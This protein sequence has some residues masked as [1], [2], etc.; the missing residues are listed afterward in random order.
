M[1]VT[2][3]RPGGALDAWDVL[4]GETRWVD[5]SDQEVGGD[6]V[7]YA[8]SFRRVH[9]RTATGQVLIWKPSTTRVAHR[10]AAGEWAA[11]LRSEP[12]WPPVGL[13]RRT[14][15]QLRG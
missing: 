6:L 2:V 10:Y 7:V 8:H 14:T 5:Y 4:A 12:E 3:Q 13:I 11:V 1:G 9:D 15:D